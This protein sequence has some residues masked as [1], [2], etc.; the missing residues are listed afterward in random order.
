VSQSSN[1]DISSW[2]RFLTIEQTD[3]A[4]LIRRSEWR[5]QLPDANRRSE[6]SHCLSPF[7]RNGNAS[8]CIMISR[9]SLSE[10][11]FGLGLTYSPRYHRF[12]K[13]VV[14][15]GYVNL[16]PQRGRDPEAG[17]VP[18]KDH[19]KGLDMPTNHLNAKPIG[20]SLCIQESPV[21]VPWSWPCF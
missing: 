17:P 10:P 11:L 6:T 18:V 21:K 8:R 20:H 13:P 4:V 1:S 15:T 2:R 7:S 3:S 14:V 19:I 9:R 12:R 5:I 16:L